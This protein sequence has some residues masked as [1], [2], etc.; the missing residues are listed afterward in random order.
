MT[1][2]QA[3]ILDLFQTLAPDERRE[4]VE[5]LSGAA[6]PR[7]HYDRLTEVQRS[8][9]DE[10]IAQALSGEVE[11]AATV[12]DRLTGRLQFAIQ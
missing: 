1:N 6:P 9:L 2:T 8:K 11:S 7:S 12:L 10:G 3:Q 5:N 4:I